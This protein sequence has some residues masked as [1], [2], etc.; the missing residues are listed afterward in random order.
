LRFQS[1]LWLNAS[2]LVN[3]AAKCKDIFQYSAPVFIRAIGSEGPS[4]GPVHTNCYHSP[5]AHMPGLPIC[6]PM[7][8]KEYKSIWSVF[9]KNDDPLLVSEHRRSYKE[10]IEFKDQVLKKS[11]VSLFLI[12][13][14]RFEQEKLKELANKE[15]L[16]LDVFNVYWL[17]PFKFK[18][19]Y[20]LSLNKTKLGLVIDS[21]YEICSISEHI[22][23]TLML[24][25]NAKVHNFGMKDVSPGCTKTK[26]NGTPNAEKILNKIKELL[27][28]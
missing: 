21:T 20:I 11:K 1:F 7:T 10:R 4:S 8:P 15:G 18:R 9:I 28:K 3:H 6:A 5:F 14:C 23:K 19:S 17:K 26:L 12:S 13:A 24:K 25:S 22:A 27:K 2:P 16:Q